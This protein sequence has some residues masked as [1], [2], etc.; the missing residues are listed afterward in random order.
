M[1]KLSGVCLGCGLIGLSDCDTRLGLQA[2]AEWISAEL[3]TGEYDPAL[4][5]TVHNSTARRRCWGP[6]RH[7]S[8]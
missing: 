2:L 8:L 7:C 6:N 3:V 4:I 5:C 1:A